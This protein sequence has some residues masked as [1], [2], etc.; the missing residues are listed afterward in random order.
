MIPSVVA[1]CHCFICT[2]YLPVPSKP[3]PFKYGKDDC[4]FCKMGIVDPKFGGEV[5][6]KKGK[7]YKFDDVICMVR[8]LKSGALNEKDISQKVIINF[9]KQN[10]FLDV[11]KTN[12]LVSPEL[13]SPMGSNAAAF[14]SQQLL[15]KP[16]QEKKGS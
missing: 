15:K 13:R 3:E 10:D 1:T 16:K 14:S 9:E 11:Y 5:I 4:Y 2:D 7:V 6:T 12:L 8:F